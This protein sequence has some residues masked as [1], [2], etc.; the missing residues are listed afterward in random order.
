MED[1]NETVP[2]G[3]DIQDATLDKEPDSGEQDDA[4]GYELRANRKHSFSKKTPRAPKRAKS[5][6]EVVDTQNL[7]FLDS[8]VVRNTLCN[9]L[10]EVVEVGDFVHVLNEE[11]DMGPL[12][13][14]VHN[15]WLDETRKH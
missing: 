15:I 3:Q 12:V 10:E 9:N 8:I 1:L 14:H 2:D 6:V 7:K 5:R 11:N 13:A 4:E